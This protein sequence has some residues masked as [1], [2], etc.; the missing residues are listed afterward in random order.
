MFLSIIENIEQI[1]IGMQII[2]CVLHI[3]RDGKELLTASYESAE[4]NQSHSSLTKESIAKVEVTESAQAASTD[5]NHKFQESQGSSFL[6]HK[7][8][9]ELAAKKSK[10]K[11]EPKCGRASCEAGKEING[12][13]FKYSNFV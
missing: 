12:K 2:N 9:K 1:N 6:T 11:N 4:E 8:N 7:E 13:V 5:E 3:F 10:E